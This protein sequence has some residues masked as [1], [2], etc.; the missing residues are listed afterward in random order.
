MCERRDRNC[1]HPNI[2]RK[3]CRSYRG[4]EGEGK[5]EDRKRLKGKGIKKEA[6]R[7]APRLFFFRIWPELE[8]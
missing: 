2:R 4:E 8:D 7:N 6:G 5:G 1:P 3:M